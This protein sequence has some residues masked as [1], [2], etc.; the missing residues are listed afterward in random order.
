LV[1]PI[2]EYTCQSCNKKFDQLVRR[3]SGDHKANCPECGSAKTARALSLFAVGAEGGAKSA[4]SEDPMC[5]RCGG[6]PG[7]C[8]MD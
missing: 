3:M 8:G 4:A 5:G 7:S 2:Y 6:A 1:V